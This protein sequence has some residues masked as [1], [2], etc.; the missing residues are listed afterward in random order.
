MTW[1]CLSCPNFYSKCL[2]QYKFHWLKHYVF[3]MFLEMWAIIHRVFLH[4]I[5]TAIKQS[6]LQAIC[7]ISDITNVKNQRIFW[8]LILICWNGM[9]RICHSSPL[10]RN[11]LRGFPLKGKKTPIGVL[12]LFRRL[13]SWG[14]TSKRYDHTTRHVKCLYPC[15]F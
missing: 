8:P 10:P 3:I 7:I 4:Y 14:C 11:K 9:A 12:W 5:N 6:N 13:F 15:S 2:I 1:F